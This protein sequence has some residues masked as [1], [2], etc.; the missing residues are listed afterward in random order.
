MSEARIALPE[1]FDFG[2]SKEFTK[3]Y[4]DLLQQSVSHIVLDFS[5]VSYLDSSALGM[6]VLLHKQAKENNIKTSIKGAK[7]TAED[8]LRMANFQKMFEFC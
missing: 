1:K 6:M 7:G 8:I 5:L 2:Y 3:Q 4:K